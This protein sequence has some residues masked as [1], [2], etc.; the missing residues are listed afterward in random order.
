MSFSLLSPR[1]QNMNQIQWIPVQPEPTNISLVAALLPDDILFLIVRLAAKD[2]L[3]TTLSL[4][5]TS[6]AVGRAAETVLYNSVKLQSRPAI[7]MFCTTLCTKGRHILAEVKALALEVPTPKLFDDFWAVVS[8]RCPN[9]ETL[10]VRE[11]EIEALLRPEMNIRPLRLSIFGAVG[12]RQSKH[13]ESLLR[14]ALQSYHAAGDSTPPEKR[15]DEPD[16]QLWS[17]LTHLHVASAWPSV[18][19]SLLFTLL[20]ARPDQ[21]GHVTHIAARAGSTHQLVAMWEEARR[22]SA[23]RVCVFQVY[24]PRKMWANI[25]PRDPRLVPFRVGLGPRDAEADHDVSEGDSG[26]ENPHWGWAEDKIKEKEALAM[27]K[28]RGW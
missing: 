9:I 16:P 25:L 1:P 7:R 8:K 27:R 19:Y 4:A 20:R 24:I 11:Q 2:D 22:L 5:L 17:R 21:L 13:R 28:A 26:G 14:T 3:P 10:T 18:P 12:N 15:H 23:L 6:K